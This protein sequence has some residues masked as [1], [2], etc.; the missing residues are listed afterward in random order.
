MGLIPEFKY[1]QVL[2]NAWNSEGSQNLSGQKFALGDCRLESLV[3]M[4]LVLYLESVLA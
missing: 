4:P 2:M 3:M 1:N